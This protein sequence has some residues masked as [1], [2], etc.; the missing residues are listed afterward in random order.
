VIRAASSGVI[1]VE[2][3]AG[4]PCGEGPAGTA[5][6]APRAGR[7]GES[8]VPEHPATTTSRTTASSSARITSPASRSRGRGQQRAST[9]NHLSNEPKRRSGHIV[10]SRHRGVNTPTPVPSTSQSFAWSDHQTPAS[11]FRPTKPPKISG[12]YRLRQGQGHCQLGVRDD[13]FGSC[14][15]NQWW[16]QPG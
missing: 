16:Y 5:N 7:F 15:H 10:Y 14:Y 9:A 13:Q 4:V 8:V 1:P 11:S 2:F 6:R 12:L 3:I